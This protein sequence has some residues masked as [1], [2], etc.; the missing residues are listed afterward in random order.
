MA[1]KIREL[2]DPA[3][4]GKK[5]QD[6]LS[7]LTQLSPRVSMAFQTN[8][9]QAVKFLNSLLPPE[10]TGDIVQDGPPEP[11]PEQ[12]QNFETALKVISDPIKATFGAMRGL[13]LDDFSVNALKSV[14][15]YAYDSMRAQMQKLVYEHQQAGQ[16]LT[17]QQKQMLSTFYGVPVQDTYGPSF[18]QFIAAQQMQQSQKPT[19][20]SQF[21]LPAIRGT[22]HQPD[23]GA[24][25]LTAGMQQGQTPFQQN[26]SRTGE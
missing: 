11:T 17:I 5:L 4:L 19:G 6:N 25:E 1:P 12:K 18:A 14:L 13:Y 21:N 8:A 2:N 3:V 23:P 7:Y 16:P 9:A 22:T 20:N 24:K 10:T 26:I 15:P